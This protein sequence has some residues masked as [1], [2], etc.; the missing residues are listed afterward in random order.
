MAKQDMIKDALVQDPV[1][2]MTS[3]E[4]NATTVQ[5]ILNSGRQTPEDGLQIDTPEVGRYRLVDLTR[6]KIVPNEKRTKRKQFI[7]RKSLNSKLT[8]KA[9]YEKCSENEIIDRLLEDM[10]PAPGWEYNPVEE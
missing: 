2:T 8:A 10:D 9:K 6:N 7:L 4:I 5:Q 1:S 3:A